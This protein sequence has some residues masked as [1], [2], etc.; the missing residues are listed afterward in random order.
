MHQ[1]QGRQRVKD[2]NRCFAASA[3]TARLACEAAWVNHIDEKYV[4]AASAKDTDRCFA[5]SAATTLLRVSPLP[6]REPLNQA[7]PSILISRVGRVRRHIKAA[8]CDLSI[9]SCTFP[10][11]DSPLDVHS[12]FLSFRS[13]PYP[14]L[15]HFVSS[16]P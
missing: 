4:P 16:L 13:I 1:C 2:T 10:E 14:P 5:A 7:D 11:P 15:F 9:L 6:P 12:S 3:E 8:Q